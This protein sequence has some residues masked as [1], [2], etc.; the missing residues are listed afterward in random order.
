MMYPTT[1]M[2]TASLRVCELLS[3]LRQLAETSTETFS[4]CPRADT[5]VHP[6]LV[7]TSP[8]RSRNACLELDVG[9]WIKSGDHTAAG[10]QRELRAHSSRP[11]AEGPAV[12][13]RKEKVEGSIAKPTTK[14]PN[15]NCNAA[16]AEVR[17]RQHSDGWYGGSDT[18]GQSCAA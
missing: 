1:S 11:G 5:R 3:A 17:E 7:V 16:S 12:R 4:C 9:H 15:R 10:H 6:L 8:P 13:E 2:G 18:A 14:F